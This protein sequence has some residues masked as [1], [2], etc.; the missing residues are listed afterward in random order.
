MLTFPMEIAA[1]PLFI[2]G[3][4]VC[5]GC[6]QRPDLPPEIFSQRK[7]VNPKPIKMRPKTL[8]NVEKYR[9]YMV[10]RENSQNGLKNGSFAVNHTGFTT[11][12]KN[13]LGGTKNANKRFIGFLSEIEK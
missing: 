5:F 4:G 3:V 11:F 7:R 10:G 6:A 8:I 9:V 2:R 13:G 1:K 12:K